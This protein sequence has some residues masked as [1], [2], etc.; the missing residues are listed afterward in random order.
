MLD[1]QPA[2][3]ATKKNETNTVIPNERI[4]GIV[5]RSDDF[6]FIVD[7]STPQRFT[8]QLALI[9]TI[10]QTMH[11]PYTDGIWGVV[12]YHDTA[13]GIRFLTEVLGFDEQIVVYGPDGRL[14]HSQF[15]WPE[16]GVV[17]VAAAD[18]ANPFA[19]VPGQPGGHYVVTSDP[20]AVWDRCVAADV[21]VIR[22]LSEPE[23]DQ[24]GLGFSIKD[25]EGNPWSFGT[26]SGEV[27][28]AETGE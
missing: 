21:E 8:I 11:H 19:P 12:A 2:N 14:H 25:I 5:T 13:A 26:Y 22:A 15:C 6:F 17:Q 10:M 1:E 9:S 3:N 23:Y 4:P 7:V 28:P 24:G 20:R 16:G 27:Q 18:P